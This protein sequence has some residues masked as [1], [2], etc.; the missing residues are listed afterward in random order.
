MPVDV[1]QLI[2][3]LACYQNKS[4]LKIRKISGP[5]TKTDRTTTLSIKSKRR[6]PRGKA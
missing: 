1:I 6:L 2:L 5:F 4:N 3:L